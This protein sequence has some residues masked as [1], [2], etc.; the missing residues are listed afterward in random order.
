MSE[1]LNF[2]PDLLRAFMMGAATPPDDYDLPHYD[3]ETDL[4]IEKVSPN[5]HQELN[6]FEKLHHQLQKA[7]K[8]IDNAIANGLKEVYIIHGNGEGVLKEKI[9][10]LLDSHPFVKSYQQCINHPRYGN[11]ATK[12]KL[13]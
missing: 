11:G 8:T 9:E 12:V 10:K 4:H 1:K 13:I 3:F 2:D 7:D 5:H 6:N